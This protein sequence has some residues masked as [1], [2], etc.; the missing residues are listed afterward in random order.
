MGDC[1]LWQGYTYKG[2]GR[3]AICGKVTPIHRW[4]YEYVYG[5]IAINKEIDHTCA[6][7]NCVNPAH[8]EAEN[9]RRAA[10]RGSYQNGWR[11]RRTHCPEGHPFDGGNL[12]LFRGARLCKACRRQ[13]Q[14]NYMARKR[15]QLSPM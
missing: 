5:L 4:I 10:A 11:A 12:A 7:R 3:A 6:Q 14:R 13:N 1:L 15:L 9:V 2:Y 8:L